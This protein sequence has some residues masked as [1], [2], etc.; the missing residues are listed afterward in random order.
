MANLDASNFY[1][2]YTLEDT[3]SMNVSEFLRY[4]LLEIGAY[5]N[6]YKDQLDYNGNDESR[7]YPITNR[8][9][10]TDYTIY[11]GKKNDWIWESNIEFKASGFTAPFVPSGI[12][13][14]DV[15]VPTGTSVSG[16]NYQLDFSQ[17]RIV[18]DSA[19]TNNPKIQVEHSLRYA[20][21]YD[22]NSTEYRRINRD[23][24][25][26]ISNSSGVIDS[27][28]NQIYLPCILVNVN[29][30]DTIR[31]S[32]L[33]SRG[34]LTN[35]NLEFNIF[36]STES[37]RKKLQDICYMLETKGFVLFNPNISPRAL[38]QNGELVNPS[39][40]WPYLYSNYPMNPG[41][42]RFTENARLFKFNNSLLPIHRSRVNIG[43]EIDVYPQ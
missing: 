35:V 42:A 38:N 16:I 41:W 18:F 25:D 11:K 7:L 22:N 5:I 20:S 37:D 3:I 6:I 34:K 2:D 30:Y 28:Y 31:G 32:Q 33:G 12:Y 17:G 9:G 39:A 19:L 8:I 10:I 36:A 24:R 21:V 13:V 4:G 15:F 29:G 40:T 14:N 23:W 43:L 1:A 26:L 27:Y